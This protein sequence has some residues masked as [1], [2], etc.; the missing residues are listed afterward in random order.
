[1]TLLVKALH[2]VVAKNKIITPEILADYIMGNAGPVSPE[3]L[4]EDYYDEIQAVIPKKPITVYRAF[5]W[6]EKL[7]KE[8][9]KA[10]HRYNPFSGN[11]PLLSFTASKQTALGIAEEKYEDYHNTYIYAISMKIDPELIYFHYQHNDIGREYAKE[12]EIT[13]DAS[14]E[15]FKI[16]K[17]YPPKG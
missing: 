10:D 1:M 7:E 8:Y 13:I 17:E 4:P 12:K 15:E 3:D 5:D 11:I 14:Y 9:T 6:P 16:L 2:R